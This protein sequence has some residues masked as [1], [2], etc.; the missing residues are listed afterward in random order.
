MGQVHGPWDQGDSSRAPYHGR[1]PIKEVV[2]LKERVAS[3]LRQLADWI[4][5]D[6]N[7]Q[8]CDSCRIVIENYWDGT[9]LTDLVM[10]NAARRMRG[11]L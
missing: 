11:R 10:K 7:L 1:N 2:R 6:K 4:S 3:I 8:K 5:N 9:K